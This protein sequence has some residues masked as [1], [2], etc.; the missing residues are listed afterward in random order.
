MIKIIK[1]GQV[2]RVKYDIVCFECFTEF[3]CDPSDLRWNLENEEPYQF[4][5]CPVCHKRINID[6]KA[7]C[8]CTKEWVPKYK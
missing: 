6:S 3:A 8:K 5:D 7:E 1:R 4:I 2:Y